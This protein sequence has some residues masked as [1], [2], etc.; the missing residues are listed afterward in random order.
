[1]ENVQQS[2]LNTLDTKKKKS[3]WNQILKEK[4]LYFMILPG[5][6]YFIIFKYIPMWGIVIAFQDYSPFLGV[7]GSEWVGLEHFKYFFTNPDFLRL[8]RNTFILA[9]YDL[10]F[11]FPAPI[12]LALMLNEIRLSFYKRTLQTLVYVPHFMSWVIIASISYVFL[13]TSGGGSE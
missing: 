6:A 4:W 1:M 10:I 5:L 2:K 8:L 11:F 13:T 7:L 9:L 3:K 12:I